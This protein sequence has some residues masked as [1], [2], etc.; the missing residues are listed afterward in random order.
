[1]KPRAPIAVSGYAQV[2][3]SGLSKVQT[4]IESNAHPRPANDPY[5]T[6]SPWIDAELLAAPKRWNVLSGGKIPQPTYAFDAAGVPKTWPMRFT[7]AHWATVLPG[8]PSG[9]YTF[10]CRSIDEKGQAQP[11]P[12]PFQK[13]GHAAIESIVINVKD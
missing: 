7:N 6:T 12:R 8:L 3:I 2:G 4:S 9:E 5:F 11:M 10:R 1:V 13:S